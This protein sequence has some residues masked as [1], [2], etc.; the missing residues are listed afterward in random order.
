MVRI[1]IRVR[2][3]VR[4]RVSLCGVEHVSEIR[5]GR[6]RCSAGCGT[7]HRA[8]QAHARPRGLME[9]SLCQALF[10]TAG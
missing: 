9:A 8:A 3:G 6:S 10:D 7:T 4:V 1:R 5:D 2:V